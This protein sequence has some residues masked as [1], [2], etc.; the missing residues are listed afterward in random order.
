MLGAAAFALVAAPAFAQ[1]AEAPAV[2]PSDLAQNVNRTLRVYTTNAR[3]CDLA[4]NGLWDRVNADLGE[5]FGAELWT[6]LREDVDRDWNSEPVQREYQ[7]LRTEVERGDY[8]MTVMRR[9]CEQ[10]LSDARASLI[11]AVDAYM[12]AQGQ[13]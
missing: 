3:A 4:D 8:D 6:Q 2:T 11:T 1:K 5:I 9:V 13:Q 12:A 10:R 7:A